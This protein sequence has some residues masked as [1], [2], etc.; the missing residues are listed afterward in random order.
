M[1]TLNDLPPPVA[2]KRGWPWTVESAAIPEAEWPRITIVTPSFNQGRFLEETIRSVLLQRY[3]N[4]EYFVIDG[5]S[6]DESVSVIE[7]Y[8]HH[9]DFCV[10][11]KDRG[12][13]HAINKGFA[14]ATGSILSWLNSD[15]VLLPGALHRLAKHAMAPHPEKSL[16]CGRSYRCD[17]DGEIFAFY[18]PPRRMSRW[19]LQVGSQLAQEATFFPKSLYDEVGPLDESLKFAMDYDFWVRC[20]Q[21]GAKFIHLPYFVSVMRFH[22]S[23]KS[24]NLQAIFD[25]E[26]AAIQHRFG[27]GRANGPILKLLAKLQYR[28]RTNLIRPLYRLVETI[29]DSIADVAAV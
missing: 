28:Y 9:L 24:M 19:M 27:G 8:A 6:T 23:S 26:S 21:N 3:P 7:R 2:N 12:Q 16:W 10:S 11:E 22:H 29:P 25:S 4:L 17:S 13:T 5:G 15:D 20:W 1:L 18:I 14:R